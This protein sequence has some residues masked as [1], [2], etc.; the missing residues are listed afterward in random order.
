VSTP[1]YATWSPPIPQCNNTLTLTS[2]QSV[3]SPNGGFTLKMQDDGNL[4]LYL[5]PR[6]YGA[7]QWLWNSGTNNHPGA[8][9]VMQAGGNL[10]V[11]SSGGMPLWNSGTSNHP[12][13]H[14]S[15]QDDG[16]LVIY[17]TAREPIWQSQTHG[18]K[19]SLTSCTTKQMGPLNANVWRLC[20]STTVWHNGRHAGVLSPDETVESCTIYS[21][22]GVG[23][24]C[25]LLSQGTI[26]LFG[27]FI[28]PYTKG[29][30]W[31]SG[32]N[33]DWLNGGMIFTN[34]DPYSLPFV[35][36]YCVY[37]RI[38]TY[39]NGTQQVQAGFPYVKGYPGAGNI[40][41]APC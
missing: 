24:N 21:P 41:P 14:V 23:W 2:G 32:Y 12:G 25:P 4:V 30:F 7:S 36:G 28:G 37:L 20:L 5:N 17:T 38:N 13:A 16:N 11:F 40:P 19:S 18:S 29:S 1:N 10:V 39:P 6:I 8:Y 9:A 3:S 34:P 22:T 26:T 35:Y 27:D 33:T 31:S 15:V